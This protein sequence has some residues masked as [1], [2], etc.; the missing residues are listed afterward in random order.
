MINRIIKEINLLL[1]KDFKINKISL[2]NNNTLQNFTIEDI[3]NISKSKSMERYTL[4]NIV[5]SKNNIIYNIKSG[6]FPF[7]EIVIDVYYK[8]TKYKKSYYFRL[9]DNIVSL[10]ESIKII[11]ILIACH[12]KIIIQ[13]L[14]K[15]NNY[16]SIF[17][18]GTEQKYGRGYNIDYLLEIYK[19][20]FKVKL[21]KP[22]LAIDTIDIIEGGTYTGDIF[23]SEF[24]NYKKN[25]YNI[26]SLPDCSGDWYNLQKDE[27]NNLE[28]WLDNALSLTNMLKTDGIIHYD[29]IVNDKRP[30]LLADYLTKKENNFTAWLIEIQPW[31]IPSVVAFRNNANY[32]NKYIKYKYK[33]YKTKRNIL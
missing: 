14:K 17:K 9:D 28:R 1:E 29:K 13:P 31:H 5:V 11:K 16:L 12:D 23:S 8:N 25:K 30:I 27:S 7:G 22:F 18:N 33:Y 2:I 20:I 26:I 32:K 4:N 10:I 3:F 6:N 19:E 21:E 15:S 24:I